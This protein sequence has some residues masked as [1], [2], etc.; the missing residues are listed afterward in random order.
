MKGLRTSLALDPT[1]GY[2]RISYVTHAMYN[3]NVGYASLLH[4][5]HPSITGITVPIDPIPRAQWSGLMS[6]EPSLIWTW[7]IPT[8]QCGSGATV[9]QCRYRYRGRWLRA[10]A[11]GSHFYP[12]PNYTV[13]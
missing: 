9:L 13:T 3:N 6:V 4:N 1:T 10:L 7:L 8:P 11:T 5:D 12:N 2:P